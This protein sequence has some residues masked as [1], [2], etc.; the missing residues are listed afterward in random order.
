MDA[1]VDYRNAALA[2]NTVF[3]C[4]VIHLPTPGGGLW[5]GPEIQ[6]A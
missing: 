3:A 2:L 4:Q 5:R 1:H 6:A